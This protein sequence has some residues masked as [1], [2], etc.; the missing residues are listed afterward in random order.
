[1]SMFGEDAWMAGD[2]ALPHQ[3]APKTRPPKAL[4]AGAQARPAGW[5]VFS[6]WC[7]L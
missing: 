5:A 3:G 6:A 4:N 2:G 7:A 1:M